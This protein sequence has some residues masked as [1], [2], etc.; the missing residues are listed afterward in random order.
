MDSTHFDAHYY[1]HCCG[2]PYCRNEH[3]LTFFGAI[4]DRIES[5]ILPASSTPPPRVLDAG[6]ALGLLVEALRTRGLDAEGIDVSEY[7][8]Q[9][10]HES[11]RPYCRVGSAADELDGRYDLIVCIEVLEHMPPEQAEA[12]VANFCRHTGD[13][14][15][16]S[17]ATDYGEATHVNVHPPEHWAELFARHGFLRDVEFDASFVTPW[18]VRYRRRTEAVP[19]IVRDY[20]RAFARVAIERSEL[21][22]QVVRF[23]REILTAAAETPRLRDQLAA[24]NRQLLDTQ[25]QLNAARDRIFHME[26]SAFWRLRELW[27]SIKSAFGGG[28][29]GR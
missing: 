7:A 21:R 3:W 14:L 26:R 25:H 23:D 28:Q 18:A 12:A 5:E 24:V 11:V 22:G 10:A 27:V 2:Q 17:S 19:R 1:A 13:V 15:F 29:T 6:C 20:E 9:Q 16:S 8:I 4:A